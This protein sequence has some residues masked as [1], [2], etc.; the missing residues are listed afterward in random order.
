MKYLASILAVSLLTSCGIMDLMTNPLA[1]EIVKDGVEL[2]VK[3][4]EALES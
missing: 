3:E 2:L 1:D 4:A